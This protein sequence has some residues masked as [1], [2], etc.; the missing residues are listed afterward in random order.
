MK[1]ILLM[2]LCLVSLSAF[3]DDDMKDDGKPF[4]EK[5]A[6]MLTK[7]D[8]RIAKMNEHKSCVQAAADKEAMKACHQKMKEHRKEMKEDWKA[9]KEEWKANKK[10][11]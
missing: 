3:S 9:K 7:I 11:K 2:S 6:M 1:K 5:K 10:K 8:E 4:E